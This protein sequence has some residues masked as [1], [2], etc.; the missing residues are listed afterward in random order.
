MSTSKF[1][2]IALVSISLLAAA[3]S[4]NAQAKGTT[5]SSSDYG[6]VAPSDAAERVIV[7]TPSTK[8]I[9]VTNGE[10]VSFIENGKKFT[11]DFN[12]YDSVSLKLSTIAPKE[13][14][15]PNVRVYVAPNPLYA[16]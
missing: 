10:T 1:S 2:S 4:M 12:S 9:N 6:S 13:L 7:L 14:G 3:A 5:A 8:W 16:G 11:W 15:Y